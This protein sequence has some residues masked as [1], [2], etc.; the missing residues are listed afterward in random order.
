MQDLLN[1]FRVALFAGDFETAERLAQGRLD[2]EG[3]NATWLNELGQVY[4]AQGRFSEALQ[5]F[6]RAICVDPQ[7][8]EALL[9]GSIVLSD[10]GFY[11]EAASRFEAAC[12]LDQSVVSA[13]PRATAGTSQKEGTAGEENGVTGRRRVAEKHL[14]LA[15]LH[16]SLGQWNDALMQC[17]K[18]CA[19]SESA[20]GRIELARALLNLERVDAAL[21]ELERAR[22]IDPRHPQI[23][24]LAALCYVV[25]SRREDALDALGRAELLSD[26]S[27]TGEILRRSFTI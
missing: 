6:D 19:T 26:H 3:E 11:D 14:E 9:N 24:V 17:E 20:D 23:H 25:Q 7:F 5:F 22:R 16:S 2:D 12:A 10:L 27:K 21:F 8:V 13:V 18:A 1:D 4:L 15:A